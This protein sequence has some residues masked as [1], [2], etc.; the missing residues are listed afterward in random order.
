MYDHL[1]GGVVHEIIIFEYSALVERFQ[2]VYVQLFRLIL[3]I[4]FVDFNHQSLRFVGS[5]Q[6]CQLILR[7]LSQ[8]V[9]K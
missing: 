3:Q 2:V 8:D 1:S 9:E 6:E 7:Q 4:F 5:A